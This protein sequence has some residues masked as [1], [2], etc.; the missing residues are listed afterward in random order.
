MPGTLVAS[1]PSR[2]A[3][4]AVPSMVS[5][6]ESAMTRGWRARTSYRRGHRH[7][8]GHRD[9]SEFARRTA[10]RGDALFTACAWAAARCDRSRLVPRRRH[11]DQ[12]LVICW[13]GGMRK[14]GRCEP[15]RPSFT[16]AGSAAS[17]CRR[18]C[19][20]SSIPLGVALKSASKA[21]ICVPIRAQGGPSQS[22]TLRIVSIRP[23]PQLSRR[24]VLAL[25]GRDCGRG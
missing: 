11:A 10:C 12:R 15:L 13:L 14:G 8:V 22:G 6:T 25:F 3:S 21:F 24:A 1:R 4:L 20:P 19:Y 16:G 17:I 18:S 5:S 7:A 9:V 23:F 2:P